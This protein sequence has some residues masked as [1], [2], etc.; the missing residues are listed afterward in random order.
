MSGT[1]TVGE[2]A[3][4]CAPRPA[5]G[6]SVEGAPFPCARACRCS[7]Q[8]LLHLLILLVV[9][10]AAGVLLIREVGGGEAAQRQRRLA[11]TRLRLE[12]RQQHQRQRGGTPKGNEGTERRYTCARDKQQ[13]TAGA[14]RRKRLT[15]KA[16]ER[17]RHQLAR[18]QRT[19]RHE[20][21]R[22]R[23]EDHASPFY[24][25]VCPLSPRLSGARLSLSR[26]VFPASRARSGFHS[27]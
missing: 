16:S 13:G 23:G 1:A 14:R 5:P 27:E 8:P 4:K 24:S 15:G 6:W 3:A 2:P 18:Q 10:L 22:A 9:L 20:R 12:Q 19:T 17:R 7:V 26:F 25:V 11:T 21:G